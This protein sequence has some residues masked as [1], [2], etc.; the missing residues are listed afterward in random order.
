VSI[1]PYIPRLQVPLYYPLSQRVVDNLIRDRKL[2]VI[3]EGRKV[4]IRAIDVETYLNAKVA[5]G[6]R[7]GRPRKAATAAET[8]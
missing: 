7:R 8:R 3:R 5:P 6:R 2:P 4:I 1:P